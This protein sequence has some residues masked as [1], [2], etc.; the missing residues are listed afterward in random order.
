MK[1]GIVF[2]QTVE[3]GDRRRAKGSRLTVLGIKRSK[4][5]GLRARLFQQELECRGGQRV[6]ARGNL[7]GRAQ[8]IIGVLDLPGH[9]AP[10]GRG[11]RSVRF[12]G[13]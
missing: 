12:L 10:Q 11:A 6:F 4:L 8:E 5:A 2:G 9:E 3:S 7:D 1:R 13:V